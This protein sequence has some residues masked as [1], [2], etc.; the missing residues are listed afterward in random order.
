MKFI[1]LASAVAATAGLVA[2]QP[3]NHLRHKHLHAHRR[4]PAPIVKAY[5]PEVI[6][7]AA[8]TVIVY[9]VNGQD[10]TAADVMEGIANGTLQ[11][12]TGG[13]MSIV[14]AT[15]TEAAVQYNAQPFA[16]PSLVAASSVAAIHVANVATATALSALS[17]PAASSGS[18]GASTIS[19]STSSNSNAGVLAAFPDGQIDCSTF[20][21]AYGALPLNYLGLGGWAGIQRPQSTLAAGFSDITTVVSSMCSGGNCCSEGSYCSYACPAGYQKSQ[22]P[23]TQGATGQS[24]GGIVCQNGKLHLTNPAL[25]GSLCMPGTS[26][27]AVMVQN[28]MS[29]GAAVCRT[30]YPGTEGETIPLTAAPGTT[31]NLTCPDSGNYFT[32][33]GLKTSAQY[34]VNPAGV[35]ADQACQWGSPAQDW[36]NYAPLNL[37]VGYSAGSAWLSIFQNAPTT[38]AKLDYSVELVGD[39]GGYANLIGRCRYSSASGQYCS[40]ENYE[41]CSSTVGC[42]VSKRARGTPSLP[43]RG[44][45]FVP[46]LMFVSLAGQRALRERHLCVLLDVAPLRSSSGVCCCCCCCCCCWWTVATR[47]VMC[48]HGTGDA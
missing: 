17:V 4:S 26:A 7:D 28:K 14:A 27:V 30:D 31:T 3:H 12:A 8:A 15:S 32:W 34:Y 46:S 23:A 36:G 10:I 13:G 44:P 38:S 25:S 37:G 33:Q 29:Q 6:D 5:I 40:G 24:V 41:T 42:T 20:P 9:E 48:P 11:W 16:T 19:A 22:W 21:S 47:R 18:T 45:R 2:A 35:P 1:A 39:A 43:F